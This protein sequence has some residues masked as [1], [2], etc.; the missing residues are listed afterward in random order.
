MSRYK[1]AQF[2]EHGSR[3]EDEVIGFIEDLRDRNDSTIRRSDLDLCKLAS[4]EFT[5]V[6]YETIRS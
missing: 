6:P 5:K 2:K 3:V 4:A 1:R